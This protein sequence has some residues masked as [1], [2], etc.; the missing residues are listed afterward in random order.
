MAAHI[1]NQPPAR[2]AQDW[3]DALA[4]LEDAGE[5]ELKQ[6]LP[7]LQ[8]HLRQW[9]CPGCAG[10]VDHNGGLKAARAKLAHPWPDGRGIAK[11]DLGNFHARTPGSKIVSKSLKLS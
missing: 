1:H 5:V 9:T 8:G 10:I 3:H 7:S 6:P 11:I 4:D 2:L